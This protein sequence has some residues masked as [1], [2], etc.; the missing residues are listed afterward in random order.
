MCCVGAPGGR[1]AGRP[2][3]CCRYRGPRRGSCAGPASPRRNQPPTRSTPRRVWTLSPTCTRISVISS[4]S[5]TAP[6][7]SPAFSFSKK[8][9]IVS[10]APMRGVYRRAPP[11]PSEPSCRTHPSGPCS[12]CASGAS[13]WCC[14]CRPTTSSR[15]CSSSPRSAST[16]RRD[17]VRRAWSTRA[18]P[19]IR[20]RIPAPPLGPARQLDAREMVA[21]PGRRAGRRVRR[22]TDDHR[23][24]LRAPP[25]GRHRLVGWPGV[26]ATGAGQ[27]DAGRGPGVRV[28]SASVRVVA[29]SEAFLDNAASNAVSRASATRRTGS[30]ELAPEGV[31]GEPAKY[32]ITR[33]SGTRVRGRRSRSRDSR[34]VGRLFGLKRRRLEPAAGAAATAATTAPAEAA[35]PLL[36]DDDGESRSSPAPPSS[37]RGSG[38]PSSRRCRHRHRVARSAWPP[39]AAVPGREVRPGRCG[40]PVLDVIEAPLEDALDLVLETE[41]RAPHDGLVRRVEPV[42]ARVRRRPGPSSATAPWSS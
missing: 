20:A 1:R 40:A 10:T 39:R 30:G 22:G 6:S 26:P 24:R 33:A 16:A 21:Q 42:E 8:T 28:R 14:D 32:R 34:R 17:A 19:G 25:H 9:S 5:A 41:R 4:I 3:R 7:R 37:R 31:L 36:P 29:E 2:H 15:P 13:D 11:T 38:R 35:P 27:G 23:R 12:I 18:E